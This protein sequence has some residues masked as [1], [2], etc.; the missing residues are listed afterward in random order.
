MNLF[1]SNPDFYPTPPEVIQQMMMGEDFI[2][3]TILEPSAGSGNIVDWLKRNGAGEVI[4]CE[5]DKHN[6]KLLHGKCQIIAEDFLTVTSDMVSHVQ[7][8]VMNPPFSR[9]AEHILHAFEIA[10]PGCTVVALCNDASLERS[11]YS[12]TNQ[13]LRETVELYGRHEYLGDV[14]KNA[15]RRTN[16]HVSLVKLYKDGEGESEFA[17][18][19]FDSV[20]LDDAGGKEGL[21]EYNF[22]RDIVN[23]FTSAVKLFDGVMKASEE[24]NEIADFYDFKT[25]I[26]ERTG[27]AKQVKQ[28]YGYL[29]IRFGAVTS[30]EKSTVVTH[31]RYKKELQKHYWHI[32]FQKLNMEKY[33]TKQ[34]REQINIFVEQQSDVPFTMKNI[35][36]VVDIVIQTNGS[37]MMTAIIEA[38]DKICSYSAENSTAGETWK[39]N[40]NYMVNKRFIVPR[41]CE[42]YKPY[43]H[44]ESYP[45]LNFGYYSDRVELEDICKALCFLTGQNYDE[46][47]S[48]RDH[49]GRENWGEWFE[50]GF[51][52]CR[53]Y[54]KGTMHLEFL[55]EDV[56]YKFNYAV[57]K[58]K[59][60]NLPKKTQKER[61]KP[62]RKKEA[63]PMAEPDGQLVMFG[64]LQTI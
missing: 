59:G 8:I 16:V 28:T 48:L 45:K 23:R 4:A 29:P 64:E 12:K 10:P 31:Q 24:I 3:K 38:F 63:A 11:S 13:Q 43:C 22:V 37:R 33:A 50:W 53:A 30:G 54:K 2:G 19:F 36:R 42:G 49:E 46:I 7:M 51:F 34:L 56:W 17:G 26:D 9:G 21:M 1:T 61:K 6:L 20:D 40:A 35:Y 41:I 58:E 14:F 60:W 25:E 52:K 18:Y 5:N 55:D 32:I 15:E 47:E 44:N 39:T 27:E 57:A 62:E